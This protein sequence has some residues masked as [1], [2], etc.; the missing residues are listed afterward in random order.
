MN[1]VERVL[2]YV[3]LPAE[4]S[5][6]EKRP[7]MEISQEWPKNGSVVFRDVN[8]RYRDG[9]PLVLKDVSFDIKAGE[10]VSIGL[11]TTINANLMLYGV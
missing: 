9:L 1:A 10:K 3:E 7:R 8:F 11:S 4:G 2:H 6:S 5:I